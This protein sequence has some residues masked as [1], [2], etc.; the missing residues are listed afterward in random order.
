MPG[1]VPHVRRGEKLR[2][3]ADHFNSMAD[4][5][6]AHA[7]R[8]LAGGASSLP[9]LARS[10]LVRV[11]ND[12]GADAD[13]FSVLGIDGVRFDPAL[14]LDAFK[15]TPVLKGKTPD[16]DKHVGRFVV[17]QEPIPDDKI[18]WAMV[19]GVTAVKINV[20]DED[21]DRFADICD[22][23]TAYLT[24]GVSGSAR[25]LY[26][27]KEGYSPSTGQQWAYVLLGTPNWF[28][29]DGSEYEVW[30]L[31]DSGGGVLKPCWDFVRMHE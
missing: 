22:G 11:Y 2:F 1:K 19:C 26:R 27:E 9:E 29:D 20:E 14:A 31:Q 4:A 18:G 7:G 28:N 10:G 12:S 3:R 25:V 24:T 6:N 21:F 17:T 16:E 13:E 30:Q 5:A 15:R 23:V 8:Q